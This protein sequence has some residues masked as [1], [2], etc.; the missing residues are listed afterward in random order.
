MGC[1]ATGEEDDSK[2]PEEAELAKRHIPGTWGEYIPSDEEDST[3]PPTLPKHSKIKQQKKRISQ[4][5]TKQN[6]CKHKN[7]N[8]E[9]TVL[10]VPIEEQ[11]SENDIIYDKSLEEEHERRW[12]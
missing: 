8:K 9:N 11:F 5:K 4:R 12:I 10:S 6:K 7:I 2:L 3:T 1:C